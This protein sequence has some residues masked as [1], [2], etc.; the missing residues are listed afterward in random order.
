VEQ[1]DVKVAA[2]AEF[3]KGISLEDQARLIDEF[4]SP[5]SAV[6]A[7][8]KAKADRAAVRMEKPVPDPSGA[9]DRA[10]RRSQRHRE[11]HMQLKRL[12]EAGWAM[13]QS[14]NA[15]QVARSMLLLEDRE[16]KSIISRLREV[17]T[18]A[19]DVAIGMESANIG[20]VLPQHPDAR[21]AEGDVTHGPR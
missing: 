2:A 4:G 15:A 10:E 9:A 21:H 8:V 18:F 5:A 3:T 20:A 6:K 16:A 11:R 17:A 14:G 19:N 13:Y 7:A 12:L 1:G